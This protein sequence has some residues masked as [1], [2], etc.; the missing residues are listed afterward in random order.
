MSLED[1]SKG[2]DRW[3]VMWQAGLGSAF[4]V[5]GFSLV[6]TLLG[7]GASAAG[8]FLQTHAYVFSKVAGTVIILFGLHTAGVL[9]IPWLYYEKRIQAGVFSPGF[10]GAFLMG[11]AFAFGWTP[12]IGPIL[13]GILLLAATQKTLYQG[14][15][16]L[17]VYSLGLG[18]PF[19]L[20][21]FGIN[22]FLR[23][24]VRYKRFIRAGEV[25]AGALLVLVG[26]LVFT[27]RLTMLIGILPKSLYK[28]AL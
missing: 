14:T 23:F 24:F 27:N 10:A 3:A 28:F 5:L 8:K 4:F 7:A 6:F 25:F 18:I 22:A 26:G 15:L 9:P 1:L 21:G 17:F 12:C 19:I 2:T 20:T 11:F 13:S 16:L